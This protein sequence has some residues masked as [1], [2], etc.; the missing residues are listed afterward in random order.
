MTFPN[1]F[2]INDPQLRDLSTIKVGNLLSEITQNESFSTKD[3]IDKTE[4]FLSFL[5]TNHFSDSQTEESIANYTKN[6]ELIKLELNK[7]KEILDEEEESRD[8]RREKKEAEA[9]SEA[10]KVFDTKSKVD[11]KIELAAKDIS[12]FM[13]KLSSSEERSIIE[14]NGISS[15]LSPIEDKYSISP[16]LIILFNTT[17]SKKDMLERIVSKAKRYQ[18][19]L[20]REPIVGFYRRLKKIIILVKYLS[21]DA[22]QRQTLEN[23]I[24]DK[25]YSPLP[26]MKT[27]TIKNYIDFLGTDSF[28]NG[29]KFVAAVLGKYEIVRGIVDETTNKKLSLRILFRI[30]NMKSELNAAIEL[31]K[32]VKIDNFYIENG[33][34]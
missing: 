19:K 6:T 21:L 26:F 7:L 5:E 30:T 33:E 11:E 9:K 29:K 13:S 15:V 22:S 20:E 28:N 12:D 1:D 10:K 27:N 2:T 16:V 34:N 25:N 24:R 8:E 18:D 3:K 32:G 23:S 31:Y 14:M 4:E 17:D